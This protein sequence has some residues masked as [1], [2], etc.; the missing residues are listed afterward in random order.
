MTGFRDAVILTCCPRRPCSA[1]SAKKKKK[2]AQI[3]IHQQGLPFAHGHLALRT[4]NDRISDYSS[5]TPSE[6]PCKIWLRHGVKKKKKMI[7]KYRKCTVKMSE[8]RNW[9]LRR[10]QHPLKQGCNICWIYEK[11]QIIKNSSLTAFHKAFKGVWRI[12][13]PPHLVAV[14]DVA[15]L[16]KTMLAFKLLYIIVNNDQIHVILAIQTNTKT[17]M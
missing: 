9:V 3:Q 16:T 11:G 1:L 8:C 17:Q 4:G 6:L 5:G 7:K 13:L 10:L 2:A 12:L 15:V 14:V